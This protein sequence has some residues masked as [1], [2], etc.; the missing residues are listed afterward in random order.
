MSRPL[1]D[2]EFKTDLKQGEM[3]I[4]IFCNEV[5]LTKTYSSLVLWLTNPLMIKIQRKSIDLYPKCFLSD[6]ET[7]FGHTFPYNN[8]Q[9]LPP[10]R[11]KKSLRKRKDPITGNSFIFTY[12]CIFILSGSCSCSL[13]NSSPSSFWIVSCCACPLA[14]GISSLS[15]LLSRSSSSSSS[16]DSCSA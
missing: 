4:G 13:S 14:S 5:I 7:T 6:V 12:S 2:D 8:L 16:Q 15:Q 10:W 11:S 1:S 3:F 9:C